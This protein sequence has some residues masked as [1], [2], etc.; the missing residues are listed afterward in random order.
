M[1]ALLFILSLFYAT[2]FWGQKDSSL[3]L[4]KTYKLIATDFN[5]DQLGNVYIVTPT[6]Q[7]KK[8]S[9][10]GDSL[11]VYNLTKRYGKLTSID[12]TNPLKIL[13]FY[14][15]YATVVV[16]DR[17]LNVTNTIDLRKQ[18]IYQVKAIA[19]SYDGQFWFYD[20]QE[21]KLKKMNE[22]GTITQQTVD[23][24]QVVTDMPSPQKII[25]NDNNIYVYDAKKG[26]LVFDYYG[27]LKTNIVL[28]GWSSF[29]AFNKTVYGL[30]NDTIQKYTIGNIMP[31]AIALPIGNKPLKM[32]VAANKIYFLYKNEIR[33]YTN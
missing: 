32:V 26:V 12:V 8:I 7:L 23:L 21:A 1:K 25:D 19:S 15:D 6:A 14:Q 2:V 16:A 3:K 24:R 11:A 29:Y 28:T 13:L 30:K 4:T 10:K 27:A 31:V 9:S 20:E 17:L 22:K 33:V 18:N 5:V